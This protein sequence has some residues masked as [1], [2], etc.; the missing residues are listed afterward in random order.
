M[1]PAGP[2]IAYMRTSA[3]APLVEVQ[4]GDVAVVICTEAH[5]QILGE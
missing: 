3:I 1:V 4:R 2:Q 5:A